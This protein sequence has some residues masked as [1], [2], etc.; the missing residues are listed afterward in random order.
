MEHEFLEQGGLRERMS[1]ARR[2]VREAGAE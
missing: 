2:A 1:R